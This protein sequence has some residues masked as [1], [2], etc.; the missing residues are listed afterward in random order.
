MTELLP[1]NIEFLTQKQQKAVRRRIQ[2]VAP[3]ADKMDDIYTDSEKERINKQLAKKKPKRS[4]SKKQ[5]LLEKYLIPDE[6]NKDI[7]YNLIT[8]KITLTFRDIDEDL[9]KVLAD[10]YLKNKVPAELETPTVIDGIN[11]FGGIRPTDS[12]FIKKIINF[13]QND[14]IPTNNFLTNPT[15]KIV[16]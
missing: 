12:E 16:P 10:R 2:R 6:F 15:G 5:Q 3:E 13:G 1:Q 14:I 7:K 11:Y 8:G 9:F 4:L